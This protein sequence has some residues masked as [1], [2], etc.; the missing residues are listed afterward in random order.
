MFS[1]A[2]L[3]QRTDFHFLLLPPKPNTADYKGTGQIPVLLT[4]SRGGMRLRGTISLFLWKSPVAA[5]TRE[6]LIQP[7]CA[8]FLGRI[9]T[10]R[11]TE[12]FVMTIGAIAAALLPLRTILTVQPKLAVG[13][14]IYNTYHPGRNTNV[15]TSANTHLGSSEKS[16]T[17]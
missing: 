17:A 11:C 7:K 12:L 5:E 14:Y 16:T 9:K 6:S 15:M 13:R 8:D 3:C 4:E 1:C 10:A 2:S